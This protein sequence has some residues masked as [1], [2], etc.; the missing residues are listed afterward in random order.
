MDLKLR[1][2]IKQVVTDHQGCKATEVPVLIAHV[3]DNIDNT[4]Q[5]T[6]SQLQWTAVP[7]LVQDLVDK[8]ELV[9]VEYVL[10]NMD[11]RIKSFLLPKGTVFG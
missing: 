1:E 3:L 2:L 8:G 11:Y 5:L 7:E 4:T 6:R 9:E 10:P